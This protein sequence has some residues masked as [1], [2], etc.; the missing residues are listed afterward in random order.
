MRAL[1]SMV[2]FWLF[3]ALAQAAPLERDALAQLIMPPF[4][5]GEP[6]NDKGVYSLLNSGGAEAGYVFETEPLAPL[7]GFSGAPINALVVLDLE[8][9]FLDVR[10]IEHNEPI[11]VSGL[12]EAPF[13]KF[14][15]QYAGLSI[16]SS[17]VV[18]TPYGDGSAG[19]SLVYLDGV[20]KATASV[21]IAHESVMA[22]ALAVAREKM[23]GIATSPPA[24]PNPE[25]DEALSWSDLL[26]QGLVTHKTVSNAE[27]DAAF[28]GTLW[29]DDDP[30]ARENPDAPYLDLWIADLGPPS[31]ARA[32]LS[33][34]GYAELQEFLTISPDDEPILV[35]E[36][37]RHGLVSPDFVRNTS[38]DWLSAEQDGLPVAL[39]DS[40][41]FVELSPDLPEAL[42]QGTA[43]ILRTDRRLGFDPARPWVLNVAAVREHGM[44]QPESGSVTLSAEHS[45]DER[46]FT[47]PGVVEP[48][49][50]W[51]EALR[52]RQGDMIVLSIFLLGLTGG[53]LFAQNPLADSRAFTP[54]RLL[55]LA[56][57]TVFIGWWG[58]GQL[59]IVTVLGVI[60]TAAEG[61]SFA[62]LVYDPFSLLIWGFAILG[63][64]LWGRGYFCGWLCP[65]GAL[66]EFASHVGRGLRLPQIEPSPKWDTRLKWLKYGL[67]AGLVAVVFVSPDQVDK[68]AEVEPF[69]TAITTHFA[70]EWYF[71]AYAAFW[72]VAGLTLF[73]GFCRYVCPL[74]A[75]MA[76]GGLLRGRSWIAR[77]VECGS[78]CQLCRVKCNYHAIKKTGEIDYSEC[79]G[80]LDC[81]SI[82]NDDTR[83][84]PR[85]LAARRGARQQAAE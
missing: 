30:E 21:R 17:I 26:E 60:R 20:S 37:A 41:L 1:I 49:P 83:C 16:S 77:R 2:V 8:G 33:E 44:F 69:K 80:C 10:L 48:V 3:A 65:F 12:G 74:G 31:I 78:P 51:Q 6:L 43:M 40:D 85:I 57:V 72:L 64:V 52:A 47:R 9:K 61:G 76:I 38:P 62:F 4:S 55:I 46:F 29:E 73:K 34:D 32:V 75:V 27:V 45:T 84:V 39:R 71:V 5:L 68:A 66:Q 50:P 58:Q 13:H 82:H 36:T 15:E 25:H 11:F 23:Q 54:L 24:H 56:F 59:S 18:G 81:V 14:F 53:L 28:A 35:I 22:A 7:P 79:F 67:L 70:R 63:F 42:H 19:G